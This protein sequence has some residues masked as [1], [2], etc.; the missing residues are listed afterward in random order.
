MSSDS[1]IDISDTWTSWCLSES[2]PLNDWAW[3]TNLQKVDYLLLDWCW[4]SYHVSDVASQQ[5]SHLLEDDSIP[6]SVVESAIG[7]IVGSLRGHCTV[8]HPT[9]AA[10]Q[11]GKS[12]FYLGK[13][14]IVDS[15]NWRE[16]VWLECLAVSDDICWITCVVSDAQALYKAKAK[17]SLLKRVCVW[18]V[19]NK[20]FAWS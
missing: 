3:E 20:P 17:Q 13:D 7:L 5:C 2:I 19:W 15:W 11:R 16:E 1:I 6:A 4:A 14:L 18:Q 10:R 12:V 8:S 9:F